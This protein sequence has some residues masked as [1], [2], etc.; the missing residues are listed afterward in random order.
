M[1]IKG[2]FYSNEVFEMYGVGSNIRIE[3]GI[4]AQQIVLNAIR[5]RASNNYFV[6]SQRVKSKYYEERENQA[7]KP[8]RLQ[9]IYNPEIINTYSNLKQQEP[10]IY[11][12]DPP[13]EIKRE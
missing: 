9:V 10:V 6:N 11:N 13:K 5:G 3:G 2:Y 7:D 8:S 4:S 1:G 12:V